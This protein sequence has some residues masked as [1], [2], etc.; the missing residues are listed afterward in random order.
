MLNDNAIRNTLLAYLRAT[1]QKIRIYQEKNIGSSICDVMAVTDKLTGYEIKSDLDNYVRLPLQV[2]AYD[3]FFDRNYIVTS[4][5]HL[6]SVAQRVPNHWGILC[7]SEDNVTVQRPAQKNREVSRRRQLSVL[8]KLELNNL[9][10]ENH[11]PQ[12][13]QK[14]KGYIA[15]KIV[16]S[17]PA[18]I[19]GKQIASELMARDYSIFNAEDYTLR[20]NAPEQ[21]YSA[22]IPEQE[23]VDSLSEEN[24]GE[25]TLDKWIELYRRAKMLSAQKVTLYKERSTPRAPHAITY[26]DIEVSLGAPWIS[27]EIINDFANHLM[28]QSG[29]NYVEYEQ[30]TGSWFVNHKQVWDTLNNARATVKYG[31]RKYN[32]LWILESTLNLREIKLRDNLGKFDEKETVAALEKQQ[33]IKEEFKHWLWQDEDRTWAVEEAYN[34][35]FSGIE[36]TE[37]SGK[38]LAFPDMNPEFQL[39]DYQKDA[40]QR[41]ISTPNTLLAFDVGAGKTF[42]MIAAAMEMRKSGLSR[43]NMFV[44]PNN[45]VGQ[46][47]NI[48]LTLYPK[49]KILTVDPKTFKAGV[50]K[51]VLEQIKNGDYDGIIIAYSCFE[52]IPVSKNFLTAQL[53]EKIAP[54]NAAI[55]A[56][57]KGYIWQGGRENALK[58]QKKYLCSLVNDFIKSLDFIPSDITFDMLEINTLFLD[59]AHNYKNLP[60]RTKLKN[61][62]GINV[63]GSPKCTGMMSKVRCVQQQNGGRG[64]VFATGTPL[65]NSI[66]DAYAMQLYLQPEMMHKTNLDIFDNWVKT[67]AEPQQ[68]CEIDVDTSRFRYVHRFAKFFNLPELSKMFTQVAVFHAMDSVQ[69]L[70]TLRQ[71]SDV[72]VKR[73]A[74]LA[75]YMESLCDRTK[76]IRSGK[77]DRTYDNMLKVST[78][79][80]KAALSLRLVGQ[81]Q[82]YDENSKIYN[83][84]ENVAKI[85]RE[86]PG[87]SQIVFCDISTPEGKKA[88]EYNIY[89]DVKR[90]LM[91]KGIPKQEIAFVHSCHSESTKRKLY[92][93]VNSG[94]V[95]VL[96]GSTF[97]LGI[98]ANVQTKLKAVHHL[99]VPWRPADMVQREGR[100]LRR[101]NENREIFIFRYITEGSFDAYSWQILETKQKFIS[102]FLIGST[103]QREAADLENDV[104]T[105]AQVK[106]LALSQPLMKKLAETENA[107][108]NARILAMKEEETRKALVEER[109]SLPGRQERL[110]KRA[111]VTNANLEYLKGLSTG[112]FSAA[113]KETGAALTTE[114]LFGRNEEKAL[115]F[116]GFSLELPQTQNEKKPYIFLQRLGERY[117]VEMGDKPAGNAAR[118]RNFLKNFEKV[119]A[120]VEEQIEAGKRRS[121]DIENLL[122]TQSVYPEQIRQ[123]TREREALLEKIH[124][125]ED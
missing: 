34:S 87:C 52:M 96:I 13:T 115:D 22:N 90:H 38:N 55:A 50:R 70:P 58:Q 28:N 19:L 16:A 123:L 59:E 66:S 60:I 53:E 69:G 46:W 62:N 76:E 37:C 82:G 86:I 98:G 64:V 15:D 84:V 65:C 2:K 80:R 117:S 74:Q 21:V 48:F 47:E 89:E 5:K 83:C 112:Q 30:I 3:R 94:K 43:K 56:I 39:F 103:Y 25:F 57:Q 27:Q 29:W 100:I 106:S 97:K 32:A 1:E 107:L 104:L 9:L 78:D 88:K 36:K 63:K 73:S 40:V 85:Y 120:Q 93:N 99:D 10:I 18:D 4:K 113:V 24:L 92:E 35:L 102:Q 116:L 91:E 42:I 14:D 111:E 105:Y 20:Q 7:V 6:A 81:E 95:R 121:I 33:K 118:I 71:Y 108:R 44:V 109:I 17:V 45:I 8:W 79:G 12:Y 124:V 49:A 11:L 122:Q 125:D 72:T 75:E 67:F 68:V 26:R 110:Q 31:T 54:I 77:I 114:F 61:L 41:I 51:K 23:I 101:G 119:A